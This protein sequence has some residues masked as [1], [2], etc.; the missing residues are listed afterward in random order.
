MKA[1]ILIAAL[2]WGLGHSTRIVPII[3]QLHQENKQI[4]LAG[5]NKQIAFWKNEGLPVTDYHE[6]ISYN[7]QLTADKG[8]L[9]NY[10]LQMP[11]FFHAILKEKKQV[12]LLHKKHHFQQIISDH[13]Y[14]FRIKNVQSIFIC[15]QL[16]IKSPILEG[17]A[18]LIHKYLM[19]KFDTIWCPDYEEKDK[20]LAGALSKVPK[21]FHKPVH[22]LGPLSRFSAESMGQ[23]HTTKPHQVLVI[24]SGPEPMKSEW[25]KQMITLGQRLPS[26]KFVLINTSVFEEQLIKNI[27]LMP[28]LSK[29]ALLPLLLESGFIISRSGYSSIMDLYYLK[30]KALL[31]ASPHQY[32]QMYL[33]KHLNGKHD[34]KCFVNWKDFEKSIIQLS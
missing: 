30:K 25:E 15:H 31:L 4:H 7:T 10:F 19:G 34:F 14:G 28:A 33:A 24:M 13:R 2:D 26:K 9:G 23:S 1:K 32:E 17:P 11:S 16:N 21:N 12:N 6:I 5:T 20:K 29:Q 3:Q 27:K 8:F 22:F 18:N